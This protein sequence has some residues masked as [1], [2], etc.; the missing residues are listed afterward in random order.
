MKT[1]LDRHQIFSLINVANVKSGLLSD[2][3]VRSSDELK[4]FIEKTKGIPILIPADEKIFNFSK[5]DIFKI[6]ERKLLDLSIGINNNF[7]L[8]LAAGSQTKI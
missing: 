7:Y 6:E 4:I 1:S 5:N 8:S 2:N 3:L